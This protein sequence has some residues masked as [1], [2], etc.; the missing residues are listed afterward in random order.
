MIVVDGRVD[1]EKLHELLATGTETTHLDFKATLDLSSGKSKDALDFVKDAVAMG[2]LPEGGYIVVGVHDD[3]RP[4]KDMAAIRA[5]EFDSAKLRQKIAGFVEAPVNII[6]RVHVVDDWAIALVY[7]Q[8]NPDALPVPFLKIGQYAGEGREM[9]KVFSPGE[10]YVREGTSNVLLR[11]GHWAQLLDRYRERVKAEA[12]RDI[13]ELVSRLV[14]S[15]SDAPSG[16]APV[17]P[18]ALGMDHATLT[19]AL[20]AAFDAG[21]SSRIRRLIIEAHEAAASPQEQV[22]RQALDELTMV[23]AVAMLHDHDDVLEQVVDALW[24]VYEQVGLPDGYAVQ[25]QG[26]DAARAAHLLDVILRVMAL[27]ALA[28][29]L[30]RWRHLPRMADRPVRTAPHYAFAS[31]LRHGPVMAARAGLLGSDGD[32]AKGGQLIS[33]TR[34][35]VS[36]SPGLRPDRPSSDVPAADA[37]APDDWLLNSICAFDLWWCVIAEAL[38]AEYEAPS[39]PYCAA[40]NQSRAQSAIDRIATDDGARRAA[41]PE[42]SDEEVSAALARVLVMAEQQSAQFGGWWDGRSAN[43][44]VDAFLRRHGH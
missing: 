6:S 43:V 41:F 19:T 18:L 22:R 36:A 4:A 23:G 29:R 11:Y 2:N 5:A 21:A 25:L 7:V 9:K 1:E 31:W 28:V 37:L 38:S 40:F 33:L 12:R 30:Q 16:A 32:S 34:S 27:G 35:L 44:A 26:H 13:D 10:V 42:A 17:P 14:E 24:T 39:Y 3:G 8:P 15:M 20:E